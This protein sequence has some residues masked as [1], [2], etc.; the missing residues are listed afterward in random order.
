MIPR[1]PIVAFA[2]AAVLSLALGQAL[3]EETAAPAE[4][5][6]EPAAAPAAPADPLRTE[7][8][9]RFAEALAERNARYAEL[10]ARATEVGLE[11]PELP[12]WEQPGWTPPE[13]PPLQRPSTPEEWQ[14][15]RQQRWEAM[16]ARAA[17]QGYE[18]PETPPWELAAQR[19]QELLERYNAYRDIIEA[20]TDE[21]KEAIAALFGNCGQR[22]GWGPRGQR[23][24]PHHGWGMGPDAWSRPEMPDMP[25]MPPMPGMMDMPELPPMSMPTP[26]A[27]PEAPAN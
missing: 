1:H 10:R 24:R 25:E 22:M 12:P 2:S 13:P 23:P 19:R 14:A 7:M 9:R 21:Q 15:L 8:E 18:M 26:P 17:E 4:A 3:A 11:L 6:A 16:R 5:A 20:M 27:A